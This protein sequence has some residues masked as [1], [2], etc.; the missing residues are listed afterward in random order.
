MTIDPRVAVEAH[1]EAFAA[2]LDAGHGYDDRLRIAMEA[3]I[4]YIVAAERDRIVRV[5][6][7][8]VERYGFR[9]AYAD[10]Y[11][12]AARIVRGEQR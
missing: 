12:H 2:A 5:I 4:P 8:A 9:T 7:E 10:A 11:A 1:K 3:A 6:D